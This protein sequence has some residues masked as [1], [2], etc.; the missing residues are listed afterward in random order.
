MECPF[1]FADVLR[2][3]D[4][5][6]PVAFAFALI[7][8]PFFAEVSDDQA[9]K[10]FYWDCLDGMFDDAIDWMRNGGRVAV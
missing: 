4:A 9:A 3:V 2:S 7:N 10:E 5:F 8:V 1:Q 6:F